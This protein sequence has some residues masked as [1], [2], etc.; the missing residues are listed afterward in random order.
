[1]QPVNLLPDTAA[2]LSLEETI[3]HYTLIMGLWAAK[4]SCLCS[5]LSVN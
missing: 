4:E 1:M 3:Q 5:C 2:W